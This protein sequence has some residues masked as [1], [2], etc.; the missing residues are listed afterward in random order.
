M[1]E[2]PDQE[3]FDALLAWIDA[4]RERAGRILYQEICPRLVKVMERRQCVAA[5]ELAYESINRVSHQVKDIALTYQGNPALYFYGV[6]R[7]VH[8]EWMDHE[9]RKRKFV[10][11]ETRIKIRSYV[12]T[13]RSE[14]NEDVERI[15]AYLEKCRQRL[16]DPEDRELILKYYEKDKRE[17]IDHRKQLAADLGITL[18]NLRMRIHRINGQLQKCIVACLNDAGSSETG[19]VSAG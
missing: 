19:D 3:E 18:N 8:H 14:T 9:R 15:H 5:E 1:T 7:N 6:L 4:D 12:A 10:E 11:E 16:Q 13:R 2:P 17:K